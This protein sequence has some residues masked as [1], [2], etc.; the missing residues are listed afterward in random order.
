M[1]SP[2]STVVNDSLRGA[3]AVIGLALIIAAPVGATQ[4]QVA[5]LE[6]RDGGAEGSTH[7]MGLTALEDRDRGGRSYVEQLASL[8]STTGSIADARHCIRRIVYAR[9]SD[10]S[11]NPAEE[12]LLGGSTAAD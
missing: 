9:S 2:R 7:G 6:P 4:L 1:G 3:A 8:L 5:P 10:P 11:A 12:L